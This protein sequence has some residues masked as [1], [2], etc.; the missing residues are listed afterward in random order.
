MRVFNKKYWPHQ[1]HVEHQREQV[2]LHEIERWCYNNF[3]SRTWTNHGFYFVFK[4]GNES[5]LFA[6]RWS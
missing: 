1:V 6:L 2:G 3:R 5:T 4:D